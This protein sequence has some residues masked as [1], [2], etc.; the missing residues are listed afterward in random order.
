M[1]NFSFIN[2]F[3]LKTISLKFTNTV[4]LPIFNQLAPEEILGY[5]EMLA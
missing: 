5:F 1:S 2:I 3:S 4:E